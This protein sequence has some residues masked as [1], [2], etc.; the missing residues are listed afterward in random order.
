M[1]GLEPAWVYS[2]GALDYLLTPPSRYI[3]RARSIMEFGYI[4]SP[5]TLSVYQFRH[6]NIF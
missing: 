5:E 3:P 2:V 4:R 6:I 1:A